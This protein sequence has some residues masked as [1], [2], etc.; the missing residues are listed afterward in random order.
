MSCKGTIQ[1]LNL[2][3]EPKSKVNCGYKYNSDKNCKNSNVNISNIP[4][5]SN[6][7]KKSI[8]LP[9]NSST[10]QVLPI[11]TNDKCNKLFANNKKYI[12]IAIDLILLYSMKS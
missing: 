4:D 6:L 12:Y 7:M 5:K 10:N 8:F 3:F 11:T 2:N 1:P 9:E